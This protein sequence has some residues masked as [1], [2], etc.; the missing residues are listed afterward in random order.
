M[1]ER[2]SCHKKISDLIKIVSRTVHAIASQ[3]SFFNF[4]LHF[5]PTSHI[6]SKSSLVKQ[7]VIL[8]Y[9]Y[10]AMENLKDVQSHS[11]VWLWVSQ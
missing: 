11:L 4:Y 3:S 5:I 1:K 9:S 6:F 10:S 7:S 2:Q 8:K